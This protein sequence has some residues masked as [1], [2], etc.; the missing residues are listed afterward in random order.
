M[1]FPQGVKN[2]KPGTALRLLRS[3]YGLKQ[4]ARD[5]NLLMKEELLKMGFNQ[6]RADPCLFVH[7]EREIRLL[8]YVDDLAAAAPDATQLD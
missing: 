1:K 8:V 2:I 3:L 5:W 6:S 7:V 4:S